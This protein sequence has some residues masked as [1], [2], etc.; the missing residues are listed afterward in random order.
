MGLH[1]DF[2]KTREG[3]RTGQ[4]N[5][6]VAGCVELDADVLVLQEA[7]WWPQE[8]SPQG[9]GGED[10]SARSALIDEVAAAVGGVAHR[11]ES[12]SVPR[13]YPVPW[14]IAVITRLAA[15]RHADI[16]LR[17][18]RRDRAMISLHLDDVG[19]TIGAG[20]HDGVHALRRRPDIWLRQWRVLRDVA[21]DHDVIVGDMN[22]WG[23]VLER[24]LVGMRRAVLGRTWPAWRPH[25][26]IDHIMVNNRVQVVE[27]TVANN[28]GSDHRAVRAVLAAR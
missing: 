15:T 23:P 13:Q 14:T 6:V 5:D 27:S 10:S 17:S 1:N 26:Q 7:C 11:Y 8:S 4:L 2:A 28:M 21:A 3:R 24:N 19:L 20:H 22:M 18:M 9:A 12:P 25:S 16:P